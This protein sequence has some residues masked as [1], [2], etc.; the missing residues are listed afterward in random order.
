MT[1]VITMAE[2]YNCR[3]LGL[4]AA[5][6]LIVCMAYGSQPH[7]APVFC[8]LSVALTDFK[9]EKVDEVDNVGARNDSSDKHCE[10]S[11]TKKKTSATI[12]VFFCRLYI[13]IYISCAHYIQNYLWDSLEG[14]FNT[15]SPFLSRCSKLGDCRV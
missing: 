1:G 10:K 14:K 9:R 3:R 15:L 2:K 6:T 8:A 11:A 12:S 5:V 13:Y 4:V 7:L